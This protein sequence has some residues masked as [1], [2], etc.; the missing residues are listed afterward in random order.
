MTHDIHNWLTDL[1]QEIERK[2]TPSNY[3]GRTN[4]KHFM[5]SIYFKLMA[6]VGMHDFGKFLQNIMTK[7]EAD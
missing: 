6:D 5:H 2:V 3:C 4:Q 1:A 7:K